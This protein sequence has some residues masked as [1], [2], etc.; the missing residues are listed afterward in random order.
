MKFTDEELKK[1]LTPEQYHVLR[2]KGTEVPFS[3]ELLQNTAT[4]D[5]QCA[6]CG[7]VIFKSTAKY[8][9]HEPGL[10][11]WPS[12]SEAVKGAVKLVPD[13]SLDMHRTEVVCTVCGSHLGHMFEAGDSPSG[14][15]FCINSCAL[16]FD[17]T[18]AKY[19]AD[20]AK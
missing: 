2:E 3:G 9:S 5:Y 20:S 14:K 17:A 8:E 13:D 18:E 15:H 10:E 1:K 7:N 19:R 16:D 11:G 4:G 6:A 12:F